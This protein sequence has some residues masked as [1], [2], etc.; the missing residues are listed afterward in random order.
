MTPR[1]LVAGVGN[2]F[3]GDDAFGVEAVRALSSEE[4]PE[5]VRVADYG[6]SGM[7]LAFDLLDGFEALILVDATPRGEEPGTVSLLD[8]G[9]GTGVTGSVPAALDAHGMQPDAVLRLL[10]ELGGRVEKVFV[11][12]CEPSDVEHRT[13]LSDP[14]REAIPEALRVVRTLVRELAVTT[15]TTEEV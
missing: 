6:T 4:L 11:V 12:G 7:H 9:D 2:I 8:L 5:R 10:G 3:L 1:I 15:A 13:G 14:V